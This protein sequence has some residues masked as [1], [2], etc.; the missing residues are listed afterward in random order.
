MMLLYICSFLVASN[1]HKKTN[2]L[3]MQSKNISNI[4]SAILC[5]FVIYFIGFRPVSGIAFIDMF[6]YNHTYNNVL[7]HYVQID[8]DKEWLWDNFSFFCKDCGLSNREY[9]FIVALMYFGFMY[10]ACAKLMRNNLFIAFV[11]CLASFSCFSYGTNGIRNGMA[12][13]ILMFAI[14]LLHKKNWTTL[15]SI[16]LM[17]MAFSI[18]RSTILPAMCALSATIFVKEPKQAM[19][20]WATSIIIS[21]IAG[22]QVTQFFSNM[23]FDDRMEN[24]ANLDENGEVMAS[25]DYNVGFRIDFILY[26]IMPII[27]AWYVTV[28]R[29]FKD[30]MY[31][32]I[33]NTYILS[34]AFWVMVIRSEQ[35]NR[36]AY[37]SWFIYPLVIA[38]PLLRMNIWED[39]DRKTAIILF[40]Y[41][42][43][44]FFMHFVYY[45]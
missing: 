28:K 24:Y 17:F 27:M 23:G 12:C 18:H 26:S 34:N 10:A 4:L 13:S 38:Y 6:M 37:L 45:A 30:K 35:S 5:A 11:F 15:V 21:L 41:A 25:S 9:F 19:F 33:A 29:N 7:D 40:L 32:I 2:R 36:F 31:N 42:G 39:Q 8:F 16:F 14:S 44:T 43:F 1:L 20:F 3:L 22:N